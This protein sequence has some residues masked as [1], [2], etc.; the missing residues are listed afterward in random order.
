[1]TKAT[2]S[3]KF[4]R[5]EL[6]QYG[7]IWNNAIVTRVASGVGWGCLLHVETPKEFFAIRITPSGLIR[8]GKLRKKTKV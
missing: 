3:D 7:F 6:N 8:F 5:Y 2:T 4:D 1:M